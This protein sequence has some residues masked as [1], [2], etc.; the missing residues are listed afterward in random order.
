MTGVIFNASHIKDKCRLCLEF[1]LESLSEK[2]PRLFW[3][4]TEKSYRLFTD[5]AST[6]GFFVKG[7]LHGVIPVS[8]ILDY[9]IR[10]RHR[11]YWTDSVTSECFAFGDFA[12]LLF[13]HIRNNT[14]CRYSQAKHQI[15]VDTTEA[16]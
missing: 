13:Q 11:I 6:K 9:L 12:I 4:Y 7:S 10:T 5:L 15:N 8:L 16:A 1:G 2:K 3:E 14:E